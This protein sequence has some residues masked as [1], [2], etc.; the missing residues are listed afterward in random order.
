[1]AE[2]EFKV[3]PSSVS[4]WILQINRRCTR[5]KMML[6]A[7]DR[8]SRVRSGP[9]GSSD[10]RGVNRVAHFSLQQYVARIPMC[11]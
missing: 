7:A 8:F 11:L 10:A 3:F 2:V 6:L 9:R 1:M 4:N 5:D